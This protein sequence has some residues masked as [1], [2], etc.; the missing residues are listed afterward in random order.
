MRV[1][2]LNVNVVLAPICMYGFR[3][4]PEFF[5]ILFVDFSSHSEKL[6]SRAN[7]AF[8]L[9]KKRQ[10]TFVEFVADTEHVENIN[11]VELLC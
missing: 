7:V 1:V 11:K 10:L 9:V 3:D 6:D 8:P 5:E 4:R 2:W